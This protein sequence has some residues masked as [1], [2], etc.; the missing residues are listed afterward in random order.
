VRPSPPE[1]LHSEQLVASS[2]DRH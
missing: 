2:A 1:Q